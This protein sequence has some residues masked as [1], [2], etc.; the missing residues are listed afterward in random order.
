MAGNAG[1]ELEFVVLFAKKAIPHPVK[2][3]IPAAIPANKSGLPFGLT[4]S[5]KSTQA[6]ATNIPAP[7]HRMNFQIGDSG[8]IMLARAVKNAAPAR[9]AMKRSISRIAPVLMID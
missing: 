5:S 2:R 4:Y 6:H 8:R 7:P 3:A 9:P 1:L